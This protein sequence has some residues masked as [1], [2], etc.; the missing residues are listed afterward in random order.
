MSIVLNLRTT[1]G[2]DVILDANTSAPAT[3]GITIGD[4]GTL[5][6][7]CDNSVNKNETEE[8]LLNKLAQQ[9]NPS[10]LSVQLPW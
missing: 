4:P 10:V 2:L 3:T 7:C 1:I 9:K 8:L 6:W 5:E